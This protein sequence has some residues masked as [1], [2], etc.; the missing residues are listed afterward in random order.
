[1]TDKNLYS[2]SELYWREKLSDDFSKVELTRVLGEK[3]EHTEKVGLK[4]DP[5][6]YSQ[7]N[8]LTKGSHQMMFV[9]L[10]LVYKVT[11]H[12]CFDRTDFLVG[13]PQRSEESGSRFIN[14]YL[15][16]GFD[17]TRDSGSVKEALIK[18]RS[19]ISELYKHQFFQLKDIYR[20][21]DLNDK[22][23]MF[24]MLENLHSQ[25]EK[26]RLIDLESCDVLFSANK[27]NMELQL[28]LLYKNCVSGSEASS[29]LAVYHQVLKSLL[30]NL[31]ADLGCIDILGKEQAEELKRF[32]RGT[33][34]IKVENVFIELFEKTV[35]RHAEKIALQDDTQVMTYWELDAHANT[36]ANYLID[37][38][39]EKNDVIAINLKNSIDYIICILAA[40]KLGIPYLPIDPKTP[41]DRISYIC[42]DSQA[43]LM[44][45]NE[46]DTQ[47]YSGMKTEIVNLRTCNFDNFEHVAW[48]TD[49]TESAYIIYTSGTTGKPKGVQ[50]SNR[51]LA[52][53]CAWHNEFYN[54]DSNDIAAKY[55]GVAFDASVWEIFPY[56]I[57]GA[58]IHIVDESI[59]MLPEQL[60][61]YY[62]DKGI[63]I[64]F[65]P[66]AVFEQFTRHRNTQLRCLLTGADKLKIYNKQTYKLYNNYGPTENSVVTTAFQVDRYYD[67]IP[68]GKPISNTE[69]YVVDSKLR[70][71]PM[72][73]AG[74]LCIAGESLADGYYKN[75]SL[76]DEKF[77]PSPFSPN[78]RMYRTGDLVKW[79]EDG[80][81]EFLGRLDHQVK[82]RGFRVELGE[83]ENVIL[84]LDGFR[85]VI[86]LAKEEKDSKF[87][88]CFYTGE[89]EM[90]IELFR[91]KLSKKLPEYMIP[92]HL[93]KLDKI[94]LTTN[95]KVDRK[96]LL[97]TFKPARIQ[98]PFESAKNPTE[99]S[100]VKIWMDVLNTERVSVTDSIFEL[101]GHSL[102]ITL[103][104]SRILE[105]FQVKVTLEDVFKLKTVRKVAE[106]IKESGKASYED[107]ERAEHK[108]FYDASSAQRRMYLLYEITPD[109]LQYNM[110][111]AMEVHGALDVERLEAAFNGLID[112]HESLRTNFCVADG[113]IS[114]KIH[115]KGSRKLEFIRESLVNEN[116]IE[117][118]FNDFIRPFDLQEDILI[119]MKLASVNELKNIIFFDMHHAISDGVS[120]SILMNEFSQ[121]YAGAELDPLKIQYKDYSEWERRNRTAEV[122]EQQKLFWKKEMSGELP[123]LNL[124]TDY[125]RPDEQD[126]NGS[127]VPLVFNK[128]TSE[129]INDLANKNDTTLFMVLLSAFKILLS[130]Y[131]MQE[132]IIVGSPVAGR[133]HRNA[134][135]II[136]MFVNTVVIR[137]QVSQALTFTDF[138]ANVKNK[139]LSVLD[140]QDYSFEKLVDDVVDERS[141]NRN[142]IFDVMFS[143]QTTNIENFNAAGLS[144]NEC[145]LGQKTEKFDISLE[146]TLKNDQIVCDF[147]YA[148][149]LFKEE[150]IK[151]MSLSFEKV[152]NVIIEN[153]NIKLSD[154]DVIT[155][156]DR[157]K[158]SGDWN[159]AEL[160]YPNNKTLIQLFDEKAE[161]HPDSVALVSGNEIL[162]YK[163]LSQKVN[164]LAQYIVESNHDAGE[165]VAILA[166][167]SE[168]MI[169]GILATLKVGCGYMPIDYK[170]PDER[171]MYMIKDSQAGVLLTKR[172]VNTDLDS[173]KV[174]DLCDQT[175]YQREWREIQKASDPSDIA[176]IIYTSGTTGNPKGV[177]VR[178]KSIIN[179][180]YF[181]EKKYPMET[182]DSYLFKTNYTFDV[183]VS[184][185]FGWFIGD[186]KLVILPNGDEKEPQKLL[187]AIAQNKVTHINFTS[188][189]Y[190][191]FFSKGIVEHLNQVKSLKYII[192]AGE[193]LKIEDVEFSRSILKFSQLENLY[194]PTE[195]SIY[196]THYSLSKEDLRSG[197]IPIG[198]PV[199]NCK[200]Y[201]LNKGMKMQPVGIPGELYISGLGV[202]DG[203][204]NNVALTNE[205]FVKDPFNPGWK[206]YKTGDLAKWNYD[207]N[208]EFLGRLDK[209]VKIR[210]HRIELGEIEACMLKLESVKQAIVIAD[211]VKNQKSLIAYYVS[212]DESQ[213]E[214]FLKKEITKHLKVF[215]PEYMVPSHLMAIQD[216]PVNKNGKVDIKALPKISISRADE[217][218]NMEASGKEEEVLLK[219]WK[220]V[221]DVKSVS[222]NDS[223]F[224]LGGDSIKA[225]QVV[226][227]LKLENM[228]LQVKDIFKWPTIRELAKHIEVLESVNPLEMGKVEGSLAL[229]PIQAWF[230]ENN[231][232]NYNHWNQSVTLQFKKRLSTHK[233]QSSVE[234][235]VDMHD[236]LRMKFEISDGDVKQ[237]NQSADKTY[238]ELSHYDLSGRNEIRDELNRISDG[239]QATL[240]IQNGPVMKLGHFTTDQGDFLI[241]AIHHLVVDGVSWRILLD[242]F[243]RIYESLETGDEVIALPKT[244]SYKKWSYELTK[245]SKSNEIKKDFNHWRKIESAHV[246]KLPNERSAKGRPSRNTVM[247]VRK[248]LNEYATEKLLKH[249]NQ[250][251]NTEINHILLAAL[252][253]TIYDTFGLEN[254]LINL[255]SH[256]REEFCSE[257]DVTRT[258]G[259]FTS[260][261]PVIFNYRDKCSIKD[262][263][264]DVKDGMKKIPKN[265]MSYGV[266]K[267]LSENKYPLARKLQPEVCFNYLGQLD[268]D[269]K[270]SLFE[271]SELGSNN[272]IGNENEMVYALDFNGKVQDGRL[273]MDLSFSQEEYTAET[274][275]GLVTAYMENLG[276]IIAHCM[277]MDEVT[278]TAS[279]ISSE[280]IDY[281][282]L[283]IYKDEINNI[284]S[285]SRL[286]PAQEGMLYHSRFDGDKEVYHETMVLELTGDICV[287]T[288]KSSFKHLVQRYDVLRTGFDYEN[289]KDHMQIVYKSVSEQV[290]YFDSSD[291]DLNPADYVDQ[292]MKQDRNTGFNL[293]DKSLA[294]LTIIKTCDQD[295]TLILSYHHIIM[296][297]WSTAR[298]LDDFFK[299]YNQLKVSSIYKLPELKSSTA[300]F[301]WLDAKDPNEAKAFWNGYLS[302]FNKPTF[303]PNV[304]KHK[305]Q[306]GLKQDVIYTIDSDKTN[307]LAD[308]AKKNNVTVNNVLQSIW[309]VLL[310]KYN[311]SDDVVY[312]FVS[313]GRN[314]QVDG[315]EDMTGLYIKTLPLRSQLDDVMSFNELTK[316][317]RNNSVDCQEHEYLS[318]AEIQALAEIKG[319]LFN[320]ILVFENYPFD[321]ESIN[322]EFSKSGFALKSFRAVEQTNYDFNLII[323]MDEI[324]N[325][326]C[327]YD[328]SKYSNDGVHQIMG[329]FMNALDQVL[330]NDGISIGEIVIV[331]QSEESNILEAQID[332]AF[333]ESFHEIEFDF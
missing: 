27:S 192:T 329:H 136:G 125:N 292:I 291:S 158:I 61:K 277:N 98:R 257:L 178:N 79:L 316:Q 56:L 253:K 262:L 58:A 331:E 113:L 63:T 104:N 222:M 28:E 293:R 83:I 227:K 18:E 176:Y 13:M 156:W 255:E 73:F 323:S 275:S 5:S 223:F 284:Q 311:N 241:M 213:K 1:M 95:D 330:E 42:E 88:I 312:G 309:A 129:K 165:I 26:S 19:D 60:N 168:E 166:D 39:I 283:E 64:G 260:L 175:L 76:T 268:R 211:E 299:L 229:T 45:V 70:L 236:V 68:I 173:V 138:L 86:V 210:G 203:Y 74:E 50:V 177:V 22:T 249:T 146:T 218:K 144:F 193:A 274:M 184:E 306:D 127:T 14:E 265:G 332:M 23:N 142:P 55:A 271:L 204:I 161:S 266:I 82:I 54:V 131:A 2:Q 122:E 258:V 296:D 189:M 200:I 46:A 20:E 209:Q 261:Y 319:D 59:K 154:I 237:V 117:E 102:N 174:L 216:V 289:F 107:I 254:I 155:D 288:L 310:Q 225:I 105:V 248:D 157:K 159:K 169:I 38:G 120:V 191:A 151:Q 181:L 133:A 164:S 242:D 307:R 226:S 321:M 318:L 232:R 37:K 145:S 140:N 315:I 201:V 270:N 17:S 205:K 235:L 21:Y 31:E 327:L 65:L 128:K 9:V 25:D 208:I 214:T 228:R 43:K 239:L 198:R 41:T 294:K 29:F 114:Q 85:E 256:G 240:D 81:L 47:K 152:M 53:L 35:I 325:I 94:P 115:P 285:I 130:K 224:D 57:K 244:T 264:I 162:T 278:V 80:N 141:L 298:M 90:D 185:I 243:K 279:D 313:S 7:L 324:I 32:G 69:V 303:L 24:I 183:S 196:A 34:S 167:R 269:G 3:K 4:L 84:N 109:S 121:L 207:G 137:S 8:H 273:Q 190:N 30:I 212:A 16:S 267:Y 172:D 171:I 126:G 220:E 108:A 282:E 322:R 48:E 304:L 148:T 230:F 110:P 250:A 40:A 119:R 297:G 163:I 259:W 333:E 132:D 194:G 301:K 143:Y 91:R 135:N 67:N 51:G 62:E 179:T 92:S 238:F 78:Q 221:L 197:N 10:M 150:T 149:A 123:V 290:D 251:Y 287:K 139:T 66:T 328:N 272:Q 160:D 234:H 71:L 96:K 295:H 252:Y 93:V 15:T 233:I 300:Y 231:F 202:T 219:T 263:I 320:S 206:M 199:D 72:G 77:V 75:E 87:L 103:I 246:D 280:N 49:L 52:N 245:F 33:E 147:S 44:I 215:L 118:K 11:I 281:R 101:G 182:G 12:R 186:G 180:L 276:D 111:A 106:F 247:S 36:Y 100:L 188:S 89:S 314:P 326:K 286:M 187:D 305:A 153:E 170:C 116:Q 97:K 302:G 308:M 99:E 317:V 217:T 195:A 6:L 134:E 124:H 112:R